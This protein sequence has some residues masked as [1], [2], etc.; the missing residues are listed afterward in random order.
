M[1]PK[2]VLDP[3]SKNDPDGGR[4]KSPLGEWMVKI[5]QAL[6]TIGLLWWLL[7]DPT[8]RTD[9]SEAIARADL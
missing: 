3:E 6:V 7:H 1:A 5:I 8:R 9:M 2:N 4:K